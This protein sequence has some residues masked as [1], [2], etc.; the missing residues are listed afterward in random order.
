M[1]MVGRLGAWSVPGPP[2]QA[3]F[4]PGAYRGRPGA[5]HIGAQIRA[6][7]CQRILELQTELALL[8]QKIARVGSRAKSDDGSRKAAPPRNYK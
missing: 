8:M 4:T 2:A 3:H 6:S 1:V 5:P 7:H